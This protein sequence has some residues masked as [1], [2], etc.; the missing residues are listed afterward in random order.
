[1]NI[2]RIKKELKTNFIKYVEYREEVDSTHLLAK[3]ITINRKNIGKVILTDRQTRGIGTKGRGWHTGNGNNIAMTI[4]INP[5]CDVKK[6]KDITVKI[7]LNIKKCIWELYSCNL[8][9]KEP[10]DLILNDKKICGILTETKLLGQMVKCLYISIGFN[11]NEENFPKEIENVATS[12][13]REFKTD[14]DRE[15]IIIRFINQLE[16]LLIKLGII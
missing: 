12:L 1:M 8:E 10:N 6:L 15:K 5:N 3:K 11:V 2:E 14:F 4:I 7:A 9:L 16:N 13:K